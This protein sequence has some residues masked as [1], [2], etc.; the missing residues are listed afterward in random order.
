[1]APIKA[2][3]I[4]NT[5]VPVP[6]SST[7]L[8]PMSSRWNASNKTSVA[9]PAGVEYC[10][11]SGSGSGIEGTLLSACSIAVRRVFI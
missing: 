1:M 9:R 3:P 10:S 4:A 5:P 8:P 7:N 11:S 2:A 6:R